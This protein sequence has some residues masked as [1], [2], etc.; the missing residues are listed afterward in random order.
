MDFLTRM[1]CDSGEE[2]SLTHTDWHRISPEWACKLWDRRGKPD[3]P[4]NDRTVSNIPGFVY[5]DDD[6]FPLEKACTKAWSQCAILNSTKLCLGALEDRQATSTQVLIY[7]NTPVALTSRSLMTVCQFYAAAFS[8][9]ES[10]IQ[11]VLEDVGEITHHPDSS[12]TDH[13]CLLRATAASLPPEA[14]EAD[15]L[16]TPHVSRLKREVWQQLADLPFSELD[17]LSRAGCL[18]CTNAV[19]DNGLTN[20]LWGLV[21]PE[22]LH[23]YNLL[24]F[25]QYQDT[26]SV[27]YYPASTNGYPSVPVCADKIN[28]PDSYAAKAV[29][30]EVIAIMTLDNLHNKGRHTYR[31]RT[32]ASRLTHLN[33]IKAL[34]AWATSRDV[35]VE[36]CAHSNWRTCNLHPHDIPTSLTLK[37]MELAHGR[38][39]SFLPSSTDF[40]ATSGGHNSTMRRRLA[41]AKAKNEH[42]S[43]IPITDSED[44]WCRSQ[45]ANSIFP[46]LQAAKGA[47]PEDC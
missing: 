27:F 40:S 26:A 47:T 46:V 45:L 38:I 21:D 29:G 9:G 16:D 18:Y 3:W 15:A 39:W 43:T 20:G 37:H 4:I 5:S 35:Y 24:H 32:I 17:P 30:S 36:V 11:G 22:S 34:S 42:V 8:K 2:C 7:T 41:Y 13:R 31:F 33:T 1:G 10:I 28:N 12:H 14:M 44:E 25:I 6:D 23:G 19:S